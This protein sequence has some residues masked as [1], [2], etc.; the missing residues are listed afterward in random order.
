M[1]WDTFL[2]NSLVSVPE[3]YAS[4]VDYIIFDSTKLNLFNARHKERRVLMFLW[5]NFKDVRSSV[6]FCT[7]FTQVLVVVK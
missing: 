6:F 7:I 2:A 4:T 5:R 3:H 1:F